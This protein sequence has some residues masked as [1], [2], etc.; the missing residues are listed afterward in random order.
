MQS[1]RRNIR[2]KDIQ[3]RRRGDVYSRR[4]GVQ[5]NEAV[6]GA[7]QHSRGDRLYPRVAE[8]QR[9]HSNGK[10]RWRYDTKQCILGGPYARIQGKN[11]NEVDS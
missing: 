4:A 5:D 7:P 6:V 8:E 3:E 1:D 9:V 11:N 2:S 10:D